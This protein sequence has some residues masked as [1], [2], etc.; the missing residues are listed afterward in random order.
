MNLESMNCDLDEIIHEAQ[1][2]KNYNN[3][4]VLPLHTSF[5]TGQD[6]WMVMPFIS[7]GSV[8]HIIKYAYP[9]VG[10][11]WGG[12]GKVAMLGQRGLGEMRGTGANQL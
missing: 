10:S 4:N 8:L 11:G 12:G 5:V 3:P 6:L 9:E 1:L 2:M 7:G